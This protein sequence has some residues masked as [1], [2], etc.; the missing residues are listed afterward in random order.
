[1]DVSD[2]KEFDN[3]SLQSHLF[4]PLKT[5]NVKYVC[6]HA[7]FETFLNQH[8]GL[9]FMFDIIIKLYSNVTPISWILV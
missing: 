3:W 1:M 4:G 9:E 7:D 5:A 6:G 2:L 8:F